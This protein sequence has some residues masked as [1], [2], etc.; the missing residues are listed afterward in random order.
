M[1]KL[2]MNIKHINLKRIF[3]IVFSMLFLTACDAPRNNPLDV[4]NSG[5]KFG[6]LTGRVQ[7]IS[8]PRRPLQGVQ[9]YCRQDNLMIKTDAQGNFE[10][11]SIIPRDDWIFF[12]HDGYHNDSLYI[13]WNGDKNLSKE[14]FL[15]AK[16]VLDSL[17][18]YSSITNRYPDIQILELYIQAG[19]E[20][21]DNDIDSVFFN[22]PELDFSSLLVYDTIEKFYEKKRIT[23][24]QLGVT[25]AEEII[26][27]SFNIEVKDHFDHLV[28]VRQVQ[29]QRIIRDEVELKSP[30]GHETVSPSPIL[31]WEPVTPGYSFTYLVE[32][33][34]D[35]TDPQLV[36]QK[37]GLASG[38]SF[39]EVDMVLPSV[40]LNN[41][42]WAVW[43]IDN[44]GNRARSKYKSFQV[45]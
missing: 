34:T 29:I 39:V 32:V 37:S 25:A 8:L 35:E 15:N 31:R 19:I 43:I 20:D 3:S 12:Y 13:D 6:T 1:I 5:R 22:S 24:T 41:Y 7:S 33:R 11:N 14:I 2:I 4:H 44:F 21:A 17:V 10:F 18:F 38:S 16:P 26:G 27:R 9:V 28:N 42:I 23:M 45:E 40:P 30:A 36:W